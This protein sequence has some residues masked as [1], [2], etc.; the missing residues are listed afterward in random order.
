M[1]HGDTITERI[2]PHTCIHK[3]IRPDHPVI[4]ATTTTRQTPQ[5]TGMAPHASDV[6]NKATCDSNAER[7]EFS[8]HI[9]GA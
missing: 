9:A 4:I 2:L 3:H 7:T 6:E 8:A 5:I 1:N